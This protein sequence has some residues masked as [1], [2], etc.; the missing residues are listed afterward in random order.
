MKGLVTKVFAALLVGWYLMSIIGFGVHTCSGSGKSFVVAFYEEMTCEEIHPEH[1]H[2]HDCCAHHHDS[3]SEP[4]DHDDCHF[5]DGEC[6]SPKS[7]C[8][9]DYQVLK[10][11]G[12]LV[13]D[14]NRGNAE[15]SSFHSS[16]IDVMTCDAGYHTSWRTIIKYIHEPESGHELLCD[17]Q[18]VLSV[19]RI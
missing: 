17:R 6:V 11:A 15:H 19:W 9:N 2:V 3:H 4:S 7:C 1:G 18:A 16:S 5:C 8:S 12:T 10:L 14:D 13:Q